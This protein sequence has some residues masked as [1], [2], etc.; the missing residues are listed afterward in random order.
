MRYGLLPLLI[1]FIFF[2]FFTW[3]WISNF[4]HYFFTDSGDGLQNVWNIWWVNKSVA[5]LHQLPWHTQFL[6]YPFGVTLV[7]QTLNPFNGFVAIG[8]LQIFSLT[9]T[10]NFLVIFSFLFGGLTAFWLCYYLTKSYW[11]SVIGGAVFTFS[12][13]HFA[14]AIGHMQLVSLEFVPLFILLWW[15][16]IKRPSYKLAIGTSFTLLLVLFCDYYYFLYSLMLASFIF[17][18]LLWR[19]EIPSLKLRSNWLPMLVFVIVTLIIVMPLPIALLLQNNRDMLTGSHPARVFSTDIATPVITGGFWYFHSLTDGY[20]RHVKGYIS[21]TTIYLGISVISVLAIAVWKRTKIHRDVVFWLAT[22]VFFGVMS[23]G[24]RLMVAGRS[25][26]KV[27]MP[28][29]IMERIVPGMKLSGMPVRMMF[30]V[31]LASAIIVAMV[32]SKVNLNKRSGQLLI[33][34][35]CTLF[36]LEMWP[37][38][39]PLTPN[40]QPRYVSVLAGLPSTGGVLDNAATSEPLQLYHQTGFEKPMVFGYVSRTPKSLEKK[41]FP[42]FA[43]TVQNKYE[44]MCHEFKL[45]YITTPKYR[46]L[47]TT[48]PIVYKDDEAIVYDLKNSPNC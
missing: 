38:K 40:T 1:Y 11:S 20:W 21:E 3:P 15:K 16:L 4:N 27:P 39:L 46:P 48:F 31:T 8:L 19:K 13:Y 24:P 26:E 47:K 37:T 9:Q 29:V 43:Y 35:F 34:A 5:E 28:Y 18:Y 30:V 17:G 36:I 45:R 22:G 10:F 7:G 12:S 41:E 23:F 25:L 32:L 2:C 42:L 6:H 44:L 14:H 33:V